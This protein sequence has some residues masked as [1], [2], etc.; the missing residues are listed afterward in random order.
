M[1]SCMR[2]FTQIVPTEK[3][4]VPCSTE[5]LSRHVESNAHEDR[6]RLSRFVGTR[7][8]VICQFASQPWD[9]SQPGQGSRFQL[10]YSLSAEAHLGARRRHRSLVAPL[11]SDAR[12]QHPPFASAKPGTDAAHPPDP[13]T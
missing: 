5:R 4:G 12:S 3:S 6:S 1:G 9:A 11:V 2:R 8:Y 10:A 7:A 13:L